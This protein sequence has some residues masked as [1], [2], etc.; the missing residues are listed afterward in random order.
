MPM[1]I[2]FR[3]GKKSQIGFIISL[4]LLLF[5]TIASYISIQN[6]LESSE[7]VEHSN[8]VIST[9]EN[10]ISF[11][12]DAETG[13]RGYLLT[14]NNTFLKPYYGSYENALLAVNNFQQ[15]TADNPAQ[16]VNASSIRGILTTRLVM[17]RKL[18]G[19]E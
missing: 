6:L 2:T 14:G 8:M 13:Q 15:L 7:L 4:V 12:K 1:N 18:I 17:L 19:Q 5:I 9:L 16:Q 11:M 10:I 3:T